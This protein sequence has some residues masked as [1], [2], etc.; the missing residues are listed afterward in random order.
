MV[1]LVVDYR[2]SHAICD[3]T[4]RVTLGLKLWGLYADGP[5]RGT[6]LV[7]DRTPLGPP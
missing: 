4:C 5:Y 3:A 6:S 1:S 2:A 7:K